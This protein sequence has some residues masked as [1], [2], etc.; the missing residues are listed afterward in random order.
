LKQLILDKTDGTP[1]FMEEV[2]QELVERRV[3]MQ[4]LGVGWVV[5][6]PTTALQLPT[7]VQGVLAAR[8]DRLAPEEKALLQ[9]LAVI[10]RQFP[11]S[12]VRQVVAQPEEVLYHLLASLQRKEFLYEQPAFPESEY[13]FK[14]ALTQEVAYGTMLHERRKALHERT[15]QALEA[16]YAAML[17]EHYRDLAHHY[18]R[19]GS[20]EKAVKYLHLAG[21]QAIQRSANAEAIIHLNTA[22]ELLKTLPGTPQRT[23]Q[24]LMLQIA[25]GSAVIAAKGYTTME[26]ERAFTRAWDLSQQIGETPQL[27]PVLTGLF[28]FYLIRGEFQFARELAE[29]CLSLAQRLQ[30]P[31]LCFVAHEELGETW[32]WLGELPLAYAQFDQALALANRQQPHYPWAWMDYVVSCQS[33]T[34]ISLWLLGYPD[35]ALTKSQEALTRARELAHPLTLVSALH[36]A[37]LLHQYRGEGQIAQRWAETEVTLATEQGFPD[38]LAWGTAL[39][40]WVLAEQGQGEASIIRIRQGVAALRAKGA[41][42]ALVLILAVLAEIYEKR[43]Q[44]EEGLT[45]LAEAWATVDRTRGYLFEAE[46]YR[47]KGTFTLQQNGERETGNREQGGNTPV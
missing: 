2:V 16:L 30:A 37:G 18:S 21:Q 40:G 13:I 25:L 42:N 26:V 23:H 3:V 14:H 6:Q 28:V 5:T 11:L 31:D 35:Q 32:F 27:F 4:E 15:G 47:L 41:E 29:Q 20:T 8:I 46:L 12:L 9:Q 1:F 19:S 45:A 43:G 17:P 24:E 39:Q 38:W 44:M 22:L 10:G 34:A 7:A 36:W 33:Y